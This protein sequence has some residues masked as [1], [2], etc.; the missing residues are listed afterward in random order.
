[1]QS[2]ARPLR[3]L[4]LMLATL[5][6]AACGNGTLDV[7]VTDTPADN[8][9]SVVIEFTGIE[10][11]NTDG[12]TTTITF[13][14]PEQIDLMQLANGGADALLQ[15]ESVPA[16]SYD[17]MQL[18]VAADENTQGESYIILTTGEQYPLYIPSGSGT[19]LTL[20]TGFTVS[21]GQTTQLNIEF[22]MRQSV[23]GPDSKGQNY[24][25]VPALRLE[26]Q[27]QL[28]T[29]TATVDLSTLATQQLGASAQVTQ[30][31]GG[32]FVFSGSAV[33]PQNGGGSS[34]VDFDP[35]PYTGETTE[36]SISFPY[37]E[38]GTYTLAATCNYNL[39]NPTAVPGQSGY[40]TLHWTVLDS[41]A[42]TAGD[43]T[44]ETLPAAK[45]SN[46]V[47]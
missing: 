27:N 39:Y 35:I 36:F 31:S 46:I 21:D 30:C 47:N 43:T 11:H 16:G 8:A 29:V 22:D 20:N 40:Q 33:T 7:N 5:T 25:L 10:L 17:W 12:D 45:T 42:V 13:S 24:I 3:L 2:I 38:S 37:L 28:G 18:E 6:L 34:L 15:G 9:T 44:T 14:T 1:M 23:T 4:G 41:V 19:G 26:N 32:L